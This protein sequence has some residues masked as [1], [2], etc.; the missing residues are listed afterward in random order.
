MTVFLSPVGFKDEFPQRV[1]QL[2]PVQ[3]S[4]NVGR[5]S[6]NGHKNLLSDSR[7]AF[8]DSAVMSRQHASLRLNK[9]TVSDQATGFEDDRSKGLS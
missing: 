6:K 3:P 4:I 5:S 2:T 1:I 9:S 7:N 8:I